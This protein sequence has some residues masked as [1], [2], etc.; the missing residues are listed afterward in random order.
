MPDLE[1]NP[2]EADEEEPGVEWDNRS[3]TLN[4]EDAE[5]RTRAWDDTDARKAAKAGR[6]LAKNQVRFD[7]IMKEDLDRIQA[8]LHPELRIPSEEAIQGQGLFD[9]S[10]IDKNIAFNTNTFK[11][12]ALRQTVHAKKASKNNGP[13]KKTDIVDPEQAGEISAPILK[14]LGIK[15]ELAKTSKERR[16]LDAKLRSAI[17]KDLIA[18]ENEQAE[19]MER[20][21]G[22]WRYVN[23][24]TY[25]Q[26]VENNELWDWATGQKLLKVEQESGLY[27]ID[28][29][30][31]STEEETLDGTTPGTT[32]IVSPETCDNDEG[33]NIPAG[34]TSFFGCRVIAEDGD[35]LKTP[36]Q[37]VDARST[38]DLEESA[39]IIRSKFDVLHLAKLSYSPGRSPGPTLRF[40]VPS[41]SSED[42]LYDEEGGDGGSPVRKEFFIPKARDGLITPPSSVNPNVTCRAFTRKK[43]A[44]TCNGA[45]FVREASPQEN[46]AAQKSPWPKFSSPMPI[47]LACVEANNR[48]GSLDRELPAPC[49]DPKPGTPLKMKPII[50]LALPPKK[51]PPQAEDGWEIIQAG[52]KKNQKDLSRLN[53]KKKTAAN[54]HAARLAEAICP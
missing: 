52:P 25:N 21:A 54:G 34:G 37:A 51:V 38:M 11:Y 53:L 30:N 26:M 24:R 1:L 48:F 45:L 4:D 23:K 36:T 46:S 15:T 31:D 44:R 8:A 2:K 33:F 32:P 42:E 17:V 10:T 40:R 43:D 35:G 22:Y 5:D 3:S 20:M 41:P 18:F 49:D 28:E 50:N 14:A 9:N 7:I 47:T 27:T 39:E 13:H 6:K 12:S 29:E 19:T 16:N